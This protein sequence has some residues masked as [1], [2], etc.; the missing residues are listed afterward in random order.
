MGFTG[1]IRYFNKQ[2]FEARQRQMADGGAWLVPDQVL[3]KTLLDI[4]LN[5]QR[6]KMQQENVESLLKELEV[7]VEVARNAH[8]DGE[9][10]R[11]ESWIMQTRQGLR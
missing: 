1:R 2:I 10:R 11:L 9:V 6:K 8:Q 3:P 5:E 7:Q 4:W